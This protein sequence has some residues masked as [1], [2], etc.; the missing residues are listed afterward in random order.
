[1]KISSKLIKLIKESNSFLISGHINPE[2]DS[3]G[4]CLALALGLK[5]LGKNNICVLSRDPV[6]EILKFLPHSKM[7]RQKPPKKEFDVFFMIDCNEPERTGL[8]NI[9][10]KKTAVIDHHVVPA[11]ERKS[12]F[13][14][15][16][17]ASIIDPGAAAAG[18]LIYKIL[19]ALKVHID[20][21]IATNLYAAIL[22]DTGGFRY[23]NASPE[24][25]MIASHL[26]QAGAKPWDIS[27]EIHESS[28]SGGMKL[29]G[30]SLST[31]EN[32]DGIA[33]ISTTKA[34]FKKTG[35]TS[36]DC[37]DFVDYPR[38]IKD[39]EVAVFFRQDKEKLYK[40]SLRSKGRVN[41]Q[42]IAKIFGG[43]GHAPAAGCA[44]KGTLKE[45]QDRVLKVIRKA[46]KES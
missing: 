21:N 30:L 28:P 10:A 27:K 16:L 1:M 26:V 37:E 12:E 14:K 19:T 7:V 11:K 23:S 46:V 8:N 17:A 38:K 15:S 34:M 36:E 43:G 3:L 25:L 42:K 39:I 4:S 32:K 33:W 5:K 9:R 22:V 13:H 45:V 2:G 18:V 31:L 20:K 35:T 44:V 6:P 40:I 29:L 24:S 41:V